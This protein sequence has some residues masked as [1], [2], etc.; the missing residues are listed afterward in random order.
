MYRAIVCYSFFGWSMSFLCGP[1]KFDLR[2]SNS[3]KRFRTNDPRFSGL[4]SHSS[5]KGFQFANRMFFPGDILAISYAEFDMYVDNIS[6]L[7]KWKFQN[8]NTPV[9]AVASRSYVL[10]LP[11]L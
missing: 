8:A 6:K 10:T 11:W 2:K 7:K 1:L 4:S 9:K 3:T 5:L